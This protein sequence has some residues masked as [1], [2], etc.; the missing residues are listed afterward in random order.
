MDN[1]YDECI[2]NL[3][4]EEELKSIRENRNP[5]ALITIIAPIVGV[6]T[7]CQNIMQF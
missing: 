7:L 2:K 6:V 5:L 4:T 1:L 3:K